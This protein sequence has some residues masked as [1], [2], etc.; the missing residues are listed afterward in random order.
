MN[1]SNISRRAP[2]AILAAASLLACNGAFAHVTLAEGSAATGSDYV[3]AFRVGHACKEAKATTGLTVRV[4]AGFSVQ[5]AEPREGWTLASS[6]GEISW[7]ANAPQN[8]LPGDEKAQFIV[9]GKLEA[10][11]GPLWFKVLQTCDVGS[12]DWAQVPAGDTARPEFPAARL[13]VLAPGSAAP[14][15]VSDAWVRR[16][17]PGQSGTGAFMKLKS[18]AATRLVG[19]STPVAGV[20]E[21]HEMK[22]EGDTMKMRALGQG[23]DLPAGQTVALT[24]GGF[25]L[26]LMD[27]KQPVAAGATVPIT[28]RFMDAKG[29]ASEQTLQV[30]V[31]VSAP[32]GAAGDSAGEHQHKH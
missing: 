7:K 23:L 13:M 21:V 3:A 22:M 8:A 27:L 20:A 5:K 31:A 12:A 18:P 11:P 2:R 30:P 9:R 15:E 32:G 26:M 28:L 19:A 14:V 1:P 6:S 4:P 10:K 17:V 24:P 16:A 29:V 25:H